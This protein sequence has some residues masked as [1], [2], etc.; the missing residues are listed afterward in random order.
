MI[1]ESKEGVTL[2][3]PKEALAQLGFNPNTKVS[4][5]VGVNNS[6]I[7]QKQVKANE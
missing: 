7:I 5:T 6:I 3:I 1:I 4:F 2:V